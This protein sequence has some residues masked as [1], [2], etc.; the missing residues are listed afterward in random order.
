MPYRRAMF[1]ANWKMN[2]NSQ[3]AHAF[4]EELLPAVSGLAADIL[5]FPPAVYLPQ[6]VAETNGSGI[7]VGAQNL[8]W[9]RSGAYTGELS[10]GMIRDV[11]ADYVL[12][13]HSE[14]RH[15]FNESSEMVTRKARAA[16]AGG[17]IPIV[18]VGETLAEREAGEALE[19]LQDD[20]AS[21]LAAVEPCPELVVAYEPVW[22][23]GTGQVAMAAD[24][25]E[26]IAY[27]RGQI[28]RLWGKDLAGQIRI[29]YG[30]SVQPDNIAD[31]MACPNIDGALIGG[32]SLK[33]AGF[34]EIIKNGLG[35]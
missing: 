1:A 35:R 5:I 3:Q 27:L 13:G 33:A 6:L 25:E 29:L 23:I 21:S 28:A 22:A 8:F 31:L 7:G 32:A 11:G 19:T 26:A 18:C 14:R 30:G 12:C 20:I 2:L 17:L 10:A 16:Q 4:V 34:R 9:E 24:A 15:H